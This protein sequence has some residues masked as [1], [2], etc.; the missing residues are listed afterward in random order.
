MAQALTTN[1]V[2]GMEELIL[3]NARLLCEM[4]SG[5]C[6]GGNSGPDPQNGWSRPVDFSEV[7]NCFAF[8]VMADVVFGE[9]LRMLTER[10][11]RWVLR[12]LEDAVKFLH[13]VR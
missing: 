8:D 9:N 6:D 12:S 3:K 5:F 10:T 2:R 11:N 1:A 4:L 13:I 7:S